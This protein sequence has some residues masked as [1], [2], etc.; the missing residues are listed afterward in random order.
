MASDKR[1]ILYKGAGINIHRGAEEALEAMLYLNDAVLL[2]IGSGDVIEKLKGMRDMLKLTEKIVFLPK[3]P[4]D[5]LRQYTM[6]ADIGLTLD[7]DT[8]IN[9]R[10]SLPNKLF[11]Y[12]HAGLPVLASP[13]KEVKKI[14]DFYKIGMTTEN[15]NPKHIAEKINDMFSDCNRFAQWKENL[16]LAS[17]ELNWENE[18]KKLLTIFH[19]VL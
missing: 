10:Y 4:L 8:N 5:E 17:Q 3:L 19:D 11:D 16:K 9:Y 14:V 12:I 7:K 2:F 6:V 1:I 15:D 13:L 18:E